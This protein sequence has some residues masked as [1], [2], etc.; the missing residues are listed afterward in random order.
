M[1]FCFRFKKEKQSKWKKSNDF[2]AEFFD[3]HTELT[4]SLLNRRSPLFCDLNVRNERKQ[5]QMSFSQYEP[6]LSTDSNKNNATN[7]HWINSAI[8]EPKHRI[9]ANQTSSTN[10]P[11][12][13]RPNSCGLKPRPRSACLDNTYM[14]R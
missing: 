2:Q 6:K 1:S 5:H 10:Q 3:R 14:L 12:F 4:E 11:S 7:G 8:H 13:I 9:V